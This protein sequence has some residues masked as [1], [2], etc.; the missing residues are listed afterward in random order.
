MGIPKEALQG[1]D[2]YRSAVW[3]GTACKDKLNLRALFACYFHPDRQWPDLVSRDILSVHIA[4]LA[5]VQS[6]MNVQI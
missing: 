2:H 4:Q 1:T 6:M 5:C 3:Y